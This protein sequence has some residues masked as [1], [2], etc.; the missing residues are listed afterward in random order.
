[1]ISSGAGWP[2]WGQAGWAGVA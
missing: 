1:M 2:V